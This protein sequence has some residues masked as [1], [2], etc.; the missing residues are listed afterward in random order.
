MLYSVDGLLVASIAAESFMFLAY[1]D[2]LLA[3]LEFSST[4]EM[5]CMVE[6]HNG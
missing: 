3:C 5:A 6:V 2:A 4:V 1:V